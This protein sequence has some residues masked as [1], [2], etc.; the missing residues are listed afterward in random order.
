MVAVACLYGCGGGGGDANSTGS[1][2]TPNN[3]VYGLNFSPY[4]GSG[5]DPNT[6][7]SVSSTQIT[8]LLTSLRGYTQWIRTFGTQNGL[9]NVPAIARQM[10]FKT[11]IGAYIGSDVNVNNSQIANLVAAAKMGNVDVAIV[12]NEVLLNNLLSE[13]QVIAYIQAVKSQVPASVQVTYADTWNTIVAHPKVIAAVDVVAVNIYPFY[14]NIP[15]AQALS[16]LQA[17]YAKS[18]Q[19]ANGKPVIITETGWPSSGSPPSFSPAAVPSSA[20]AVAYFSAAETWARSLNLPLFYFEAYD[21]PW[22]AKYGDYPSWGI[23]DTNGNLKPGTAA[24]FQK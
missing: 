15:I 10:G 16:A 19:A 8:S 1:A 12:G 7:S 20:N 22:K 21:E 9:E 5:Q 2:A 11:A 4:V 17:D 23:W 14:E 18:V 3:P 13:G 6:G 24:V